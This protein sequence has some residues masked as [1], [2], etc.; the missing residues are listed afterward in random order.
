M[1]QILSLEKLAALRAI[2]PIDVLEWLA[3]T[4]AEK[5]PE[6]VNI[7]VVDQLCAY[8]DPVKRDAL[9]LPGAFEIRVGGTFSDIIPALLLIASPAAPVIKMRE[10]PG[11]GFLGDSEELLH[12]WTGIFRNFNFPG[13]PNWSGVEVV[14][15]ERTEMYNYIARQA[16]FII[17]TNETAGWANVIL[18]FKAKELAA[19][20]KDLLAEYRSPQCN[21]R[22]KF[23]LDYKKSPISRGAAMQLYGH[24][25]GILLISTAALEELDIDLSDYPHSRSMQGTIVEE[26]ARIA[27]LWLPDTYPK[28]VESFL[29]RAVGTVG[30]HRDELIIPELWCRG[31]LGDRLKPADLQ[32]DL[33]LAELAA[34]LR[35][36]W[37]QVYITT[38]AQEQGKRAVLITNGISGAKGGIAA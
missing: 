16:H 13:F 27:D 33:V 6:E 19:V 4:P 18:R 9:D 23:L 20:I 3:N 22:R 31:H 35:N 14:P 2:I 29:Q 25:N 17:R 38:C 36:E 21:A 11:D 37:R 12:T 34:V 1:L 15:M 28:H 10:N 5:L 30:I 32:Q 26:F 24:G 8:M 7:A